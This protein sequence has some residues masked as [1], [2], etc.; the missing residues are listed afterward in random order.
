M[1]MLTSWLSIANMLQ[2]H[3]RFIA[4]K[5]EIDGT[6]TAHRDRVIGVDVV[7]FKL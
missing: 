3:R 2:I 4:R 7:L 6:A 1:Q 5:R